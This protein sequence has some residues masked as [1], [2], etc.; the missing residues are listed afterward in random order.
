[1]NSRNRR[2]PRRSVRAVSS[3]VITIAAACLL[4][5]CSR[6]AGAVPETDLVELQ[7]KD[8][9]SRV[10]VSASVDSEEV[11]ALTTTLTGAVTEIDVRVGQP[12]QEGQVV[13]RLDTSQLQRDLEAQRADRLTS[14]ASAQNEI[15]RAQQ[16]LQQQ[17]DALDNGLNAS[18]VQAQSAQREAQSGYN[19][20]QAVF[21]Q[22][23]AEIQGGHDPALLEQGKAVEAARRN[24]DAVAM[25]SVRANLASHL[26]ALAEQPDQISPVLG[27]LESDDKYVSAERDLETAQQGFEHALFAVDADLAAK[28]RAVAQAFNAKSEADLGVEV[29]RFAAQQQV[30]TSAAGVDQARRVRDASQQAAAIAESKLNIDIQ[31]GE[32]RAPVNGVVTEVIAERGKAASGHLLTVADPKKLVLHAN[33]NEVDSGRVSAGDEV[34]FTTPSTGTKQ[35]RGRVTEVSPVAAKPSSAAE[36]PNTAPAR[37]EFPVSIEVVGDTEG[38]RIGGSAKVQI[39]TGTSKDTLTVPREAVID[40]NGRYSILTLREVDGGKQEFEIQESEIQLGIVTDLE[41]EVLGVSEGTRVL[42]SP[43]EYRD[44]VGE[45][46]ALDAPR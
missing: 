29:A 37:P 26:A 8:L 12:V 13:A 27:I 39:T 45:R 11:V 16:Q 21:N 35:F 9:A 42:R 4:A 44:R 32:V 46:V 25:E 38:L 14:D 31:S 18:I 33:V 20:A 30:D 22:R 43:G 10:A 23:I 28:Q 24:L 1:M 3:A 15:E 17:Q 19:E 6:G 36:G 7:P 2:R 41:A 40:D 34:T 5:G